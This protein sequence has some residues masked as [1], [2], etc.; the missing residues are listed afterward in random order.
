MGRNA[1]LSRQLH[2]NS[3]NFTKYQTAQYELS[4]WSIIPS[5]VDSLS[6]WLVS[7]RR[8]I[9]G[10]MH[11]SLA[12]DTT[13]SVFHND[14]NAMLVIRCPFWYMSEICAVV[15]QF[16]YLCLTDKIMCTSR[17]TLK[18]NH[19]PYD[20]RLKWIMAQR[21]GSGW[22]RSQQGIKSQMSDSSGSIKTINL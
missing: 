19:I 9:A 16:C 20:H 18:L 21:T 15:C 6:H 12:V 8:I 13:R 10:N 4:S 11:I 17:Q 7:G 14:R 3:A 5:L 2:T 1:D 22:P